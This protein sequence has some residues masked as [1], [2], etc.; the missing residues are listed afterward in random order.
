M[1]SDESETQYENEGWDI[2]METTNIISQPGIGWTYSEETGFRP[3]Q[4]HKSWNWSDDQLCWVSPL[5]RPK[6]EGKH[7]EWNETDQQWEPY[8][9]IHNPETNFWEI[10]KD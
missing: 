10:V 2:A 1:W 6:T 8:T 5:P 7:Y 3:P 9:A 4:P